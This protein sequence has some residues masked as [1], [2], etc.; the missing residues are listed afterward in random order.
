MLSQTAEYALRAV[1][2][3]AEHQEE[4]WVRVDDVAERL[5]VPRNYL[6]K[7]LHQLGREEILVS[8]RGPGGGFQLAV[9][10][11]SLPLLRVVDVFDRMAGRSGCLLGRPRCSETNPCAAH[12]RW[13]AALE[14]MLNFFSGT[15][16]A[17]L[18]DPDSEAGLVWRRGSGW[19]RPEEEEE[20]AREAEPA[21]TGAGG[22]PPESRDGSTLRGGVRG[23]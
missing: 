23:P 2:H 3:I 12:A 20:G 1:L 7:I 6:S 15:S 14:P 17:D 21:A 19:I 10:P 9:P 8:A 18:M 4:G 16:V 11:A 13:K 22:N 5:S